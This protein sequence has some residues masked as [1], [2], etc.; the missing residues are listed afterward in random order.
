MKRFASLIALV[1][2]LMLSLAVL[3]YVWLRESSEIEP[4]P[5][6]SHTNVIIAPGSDAGAPMPKV[7]PQGPARV[8][9][10]IVGIG[11]VLGM[12]KR[13]AVIRGTVP[14]SPAA[15]AGLAGNFLIRKI[16]DVVIEGMNLQ[17]CV[18]LI[19]GPAGSK[20]RLELFDVDANEGRTV[21][22]TRRKI[23][24]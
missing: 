20:V 18:E 15:E 8:R 23:Q 3:C 1:L 4:I 19:R 2:F 5:A 12:D 14:D 9:E 10:E 7:H 11:A 21:E 13:V 22:L 24:L 6:I 17:E 16:D